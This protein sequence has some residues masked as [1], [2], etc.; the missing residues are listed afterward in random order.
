MA[1]ASF[2]FCVGFGLKA[3]PIRPARAAVFVHICFHLGFAL[4]GRPA[5][6]AVFCACFFFFLGFIL[7]ARLVAPVP[8]P[9]WSGFALDHESYLFEASTLMA[10]HVQLWTWHLQNVFRM[11]PIH[12]ECE[13][14]S[15]HNTVE[16]PLLQKVV[17]FWGRY[18]RKAVH[19]FRGWKILVAG[20]SR[21]VEILALFAHTDTI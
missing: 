17:G 9:L 5:R 4:I 19:M 18:H 12:G 2:L 20:R 11:L 3:R 1:S 10:K 16:F 21:V 13:L 6:H 7:P 8:F 15:T 14:C